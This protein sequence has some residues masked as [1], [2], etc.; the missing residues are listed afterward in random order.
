MI[1]INLTRV[2]LLGAVFLSSILALFLGGENLLKIISWIFLWQLITVT[3]DI[4]YVDL[5]FSFLLFCVAQLIF[6][7]FKRLIYKCEI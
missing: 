5:Y 1:E 6:I 7:K 4:W 3:N 2:N